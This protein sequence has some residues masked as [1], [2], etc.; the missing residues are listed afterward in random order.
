MTTILISRHENHTKQN[1]QHSFRRIHNQS[2]H[3]QN[4]VSS[5]LCTTF[6]DHHHTTNHCADTCIK[7]LFAKPPKRTKHCIKRQSLT[8]TTPTYQP[9]PTTIASVARQSRLYHHV[10]SHVQKIKQS[11]TQSVLEPLICLVHHA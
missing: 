9:L 1:V 2:P 6:N 11:H 8:R 4:R 10:P 3:T 5:W 7:D